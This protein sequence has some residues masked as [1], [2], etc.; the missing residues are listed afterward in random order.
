M[1]PICTKK[2]DKRIILK[3]HKWINFEDKDKAYVQYE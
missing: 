2:P 1:I 3:N